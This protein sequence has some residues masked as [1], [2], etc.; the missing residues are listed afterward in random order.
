MREKE[1]NSLKL[2]G[3]E[4]RLKTQR[5]ER[6]NLQCKRELLELEKIIAGLKEEKQ[7]FDIKINREQSKNDYLKF[8]NE[9]L[10][11]Q[12]FA[13]ADAAAKS[14]TK[15]NKLLQ[16]KKEIVNQKITDYL[17]TNLDFHDIKLN[18]YFNQLGNWNYEV[19]LYIYNIL[20]CFIKKKAI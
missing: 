13:L 7:E 9:I 17:K 16:E 15:I 3:E 12:T 14:E 5:Q 6:E 10:E 8:Q 1:I 19:T 2:S 18:D 11:K 20:I 4:S